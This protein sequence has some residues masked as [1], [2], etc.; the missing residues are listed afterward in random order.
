M[1]ENIIGHKA[2]VSRLEEEIGK[3]TF[4]QAVLISGPEFGGKGTIALETARALTCTEGV[5]RWNCD[6]PSCRLHRVLQNPETIVLGPRDFIAEIVL[7]AGTLLAD[8]KAVRVYLFIRAIRKVLLRGD[9]RFWPEKR[10]SSLFPLMERLNEA[11]TVLE[12]PAALPESAEI[13]ERTVNSLVNDATKMAQALPDDLVPVDVVRN[14]A[15]WAH[16]SAARSK[17]I[18][19]LEEAQSLQESARNAMLKILE[20]PPVDFHFILTSSRPSAMIPTILSRVRKYDLSER[21]L[22][23]QQTVQS[24]IFGVKDSPG[25]LRAFFR[26]AVIPEETDTDAMIDRLTAVIEGKWFD[27]EVLLADFEL[28]SVRIGERGAFRFLTESVLER[29]DLSSVKVDVV[30]RI[31]RF[32]RELLVHTDWIAQRNMNPRQ[33]YVNLLMSLQVVTPG[34]HE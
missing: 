15:T 11:L 19:I 20:E 31:R 16:T 2:I 5:A 14:I 8:P 23:D 18:V 28:L 22:R 21:S 32:S 6:C 25:S 13:L 30:E 7:S 29:F 10:I 3:G 4:P 24:R 34:V 17:K 1:F 9:P 27:E 26:A 33:V 12:P